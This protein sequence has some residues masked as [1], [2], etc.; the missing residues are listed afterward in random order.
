MIGFSLSMVYILKNTV[1]WYHEI[2]GLIG[3]ILLSCFDFD[4][5][6]L[7]EE[8]QADVLFSEGQKGTSFPKIKV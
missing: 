6:E 5:C 3:A 2:V 8:T 7:N 1:S 4:A